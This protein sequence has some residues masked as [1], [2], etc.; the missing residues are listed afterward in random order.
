V[1]TQTRTDISSVLQ[2]RSETTNQYEQKVI[3]LSFFLLYFGFD[4]TAQGCSWGANQL[5]SWCH[6]VIYMQLRWLAQKWAKM[7]DFKSHLIRSNLVY[8]QSSVV[9]IVKW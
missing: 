9:A 8:I 7:A 3:K 4:V 2:T 6:N 1:S 5:N